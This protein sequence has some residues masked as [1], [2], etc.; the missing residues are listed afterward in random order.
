MSW[1]RWTD[2]HGGKCCLVLWISLQRMV[3]CGLPKK[4]KLHNDTL[5]TVC[6]LCLW[7]LMPALMYEFAP[8]SRSVLLHFLCH[9]RPFTRSHLA[10]N[11]L[12]FVP[13][14]WY[15]MR[16]KLKHQHLRHSTVDTSSSS[17]TYSKGIDIYTISI[18]SIFQGLHELRHGLSA[19]TTPNCSVLLFV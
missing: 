18:L 12:S 2:R 15:A 10:I 5:A 6:F 9:R 3:S 4:Q 8:A 14:P 16:T 13:F 19:R 1:T 17:Q 11:V 7:Y